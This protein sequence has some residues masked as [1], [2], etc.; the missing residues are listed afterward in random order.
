M[1]AVIK[2]VCWTVSQ[3]V[4]NVFKERLEDA[5][6]RLEP[7]ESVLKGYKQGR[8]KYEQICNTHWVLDLK[9]TTVQDL[10]EVCK[11]KL[12]KYKFHTSMLRDMNLTHEQM[13]YMVENGSLR[14]PNF[15]VV[16]TAGATHQEISEY[17]CKGYLANKPNSCDYLVMGANAN[18]LYHYQHIKAMYGLISSSVLHE[19]KE[20]NDKIM[21]ACRDGKATRPT[22]E[23][24]LSWGMHI[25]N[26]LAYAEK[27]LVNGTLRIEQC[28]DFSEIQRQLCVEVGL[29][30]DTGHLMPCPCC[31]T[32]KYCLIPCRGTGNAHEHPMCSDCFQEWVYKYNKRTC[33]TCRADLILEN[34]VN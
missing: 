21:E 33:P 28:T 7:V 5:L 3:L 22:V 13:I 25:D 23:D 34:I 15:Q 26:M 9:K 29:L 11:L 14:E 17:V 30:R 20:T 8:F 4:E 1:K 27:G 6:N 32:K 24:L 12:V 18:Q 16:W 10:T 19:L 2:A 31:L